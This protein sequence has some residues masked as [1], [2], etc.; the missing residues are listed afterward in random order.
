ML[1]LL[2]TQGNINTSNNNISAKI[3]SSDHILLG[4]YYNYAVVTLGKGSLDYSKYGSVEGEFVSLQ[5]SQWT[6]EGR[7]KELKPTEA[8][9]MT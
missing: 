8:L 4:K 9:N 7:L 2:L 6:A 5:N 3:Q 1:L